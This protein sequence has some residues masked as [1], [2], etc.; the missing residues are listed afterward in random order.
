MFYKYITLIII[1]LFG[2]S[3]AFSNETSFNGKFVQGGIVIGQNK[4]AKEVYFN[5]KNLKVSKDG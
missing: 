4:F 2:T 3:V 5:D 1:I